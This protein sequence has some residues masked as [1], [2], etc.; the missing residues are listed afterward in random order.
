MKL[1][2]VALIVLVV[3]I[4]G[5]A[6]QVG[7]KPSPRPASPEKTPAASEALKPSPEIQ[8]IISPVISEEPKENR[9]EVSF[10]PISQ[11][12]GSP[13]S[14]KDSLYIRQTNGPSAGGIKF[15]MDFSQKNPD[16]IYADHFKSA[17]GGNSWTEFTMPAKTPVNSIA[18]D[19]ND[20]NTVYLSSTNIIFKSTDG[21][22]TWKELQSMGPH[23]EKEGWGGQI[24]ASISIDPSDS[25]TIYAGTTHGDLFKSIDGGSIWTDISSKINSK[26]PISR[27]AFNPKNT[28]EV[29]VSTGL[30][31][32]SSLSDKPKTG[33]GLFKSTDGGET[34][35]KAQNEFSSFLVQDVDVLGST[36]YVTTRTGPDTLDDWEGV[37]KSEDSGKTWKK[38]IDSRK[39]FGFDI[40]GIGHAA[41][42]PKDE[43][44]AIV[45][46][47]S[48][49]DEN[50]KEVSFI[51]TEDGGKTWKEVTEKE[52][53]QYT[54][55]LK[56]TGD[57]R[58]Y[59]QDYYRPFMK[60]GDNGKTWGWSASGIRTSRI[61]S[62]EI[63][64]KNRNSVFAGTTD[65]ALHKTYDGGNTWIRIATKLSATYIATF[66]FHPLDI[67][68]FFFG[69]SGPVDAATGRAFGAP[70]FD[71]GLYYTKD[72]G[73][74]ITKS[75]NLVH[76][77][78]DGNQQLE[79]YDIFVHPTK[80]NI[81]LVGTTSEGIY[82]SQDGGEA[83]EEANTGVPEE[84][85]YWNLIFDDE[86]EDQTEKDCREK[87]A[88]KEEVPSAC[89]YY[90]TK[91]SMSLFLNPHNENEIWYT[92]LNGVFVSK[93]IGKT[94]NW[95]SNDFK[96]IH[97][98]FMAFDPL[99]PN[100][101]YVG[102]HQGAIKDG[103]IVESSKGLFISKDGGKTWKQVQDG[104]GEGRDI[105][106]IAVNP[107]DPNFVAVGT[108]GPFYISK[109]RGKTWQT[110]EADILAEVDEIRIDK[111]AKTIYLGTKSTGV[112]RGIIDYDASKPAIV[113]LT[114]VSHPKSVKGGQTFEIIVSADNLGSGMSSLPVN[115]EIGNK[116]SSGTLQ[117]SGAD[118]A[119]G[120][121]SVSISN[122]GKYD[123]I[124][125]GIDYGDL[126]VV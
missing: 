91:T 56:F 46:I 2:L 107:K 76:P 62:M 84:G 81:M 68:T 34:F 124:V 24:A 120:R 113:G 44:R 80:P 88:K 50:G 64:P 110:I 11:T 103:K 96:N 51:L 117:I 41:I 3:L 90:A 83:W 125:N 95:L 1:I 98:H 10:S 14:I 100:I 15:G 92:T 104:P 121:F 77:K 86:R 123:V 105:R 12:Q 63:H 87:Y 8:G 70:G 38:L 13:G 109:D 122:P 60:S 26:S 36:V 74:T 23:P 6:T 94:W 16:I 59:A 55:E 72:G 67:N 18:V 89:F 35:S 27:I 93:N 29:Y 82:R 48:W 5:C 66:K 28:K 37:Y 75:K 112:W 111:D 9:I 45:S 33:D 85:F 40:G 116:T 52:P 47:S 101:I 97:V 108:E 114:G 73:K 25:K 126:E 61:H 102:S 17:D 20:P 21:A 32:L 7:E 115:L 43:N 69:V 71:T 31:Y 58:V 79:I 39:P 65:G 106:A 119:A 99:D 42:D 19:P 22:Q 49:P 53:I 118:Q 57:G 30:W 54:H 4:S 78:L